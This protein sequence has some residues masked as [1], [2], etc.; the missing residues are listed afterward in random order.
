MWIS[1]LPVCTIPL[2]ISSVL[3]GLKILAA[4]SANLQSRDQTL[5]PFILHENMQ[6]KSH[7]ACQAKGIYCLAFYRKGLSSLDLWC[8]DDFRNLY[9]WAEPLPWIPDELIHWISPEC[10]KCTNSSCVLSVC[11]VLQSSLSW[12]VATQSC[13]QS[14]ET[15]G[16]SRLTP[17]FE[18][19]V[20]SCWKYVFR[21]Q[22]LLL[23]SLDPILP[24][25]GII[26]VS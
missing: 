20:Q 14:R 12:L 18:L 11:S 26:I 1:S 9:L 13:Q 10:L 7:V 3:M 5:L 19:Y 15:P 6:V 22:P 17:S 24:S 23:P 8:G 16:A 21:F 2:V 25:L 4:R